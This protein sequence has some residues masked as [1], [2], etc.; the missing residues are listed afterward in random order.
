M[1]FRHPFFNNLRLDIGWSYAEHLKAVDSDNKPILEIRRLAGTDIKTPLNTVIRADAKCKVQ[2]VFVDPKNPYRNFI[3]LQYP[4]HF[5]EL[6][7]ILKP[8]VRVG[9]IIS[10][11][12]EIARTGASNRWLHVGRLNG[13]NLKT[14]KRVNPEP[15]LKAYSA[16]KTA[17]PLAPPAVIKPLPPKVPP[18]AEKP[19][20][21][22]PGAPKTTS[23]AVNS[24]FR[25]TFNRE[26]VIRIIE[27]IKAKFSSRKFWFPLL[28]V[29]GNLALVVA[30]D[31]SFQDAIDAI[32]KSPIVLLWLGLEAGVD[33]SRLFGLKK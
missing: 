18:P 14:A 33:I 32:S 29:L 11:G 25:F 4:D 6:G 31:K 28:V 20:V 30:G 26:V 12:V 10:A 9:Q 21:V 1:A 19:V 22:P 15:L 7:H 27:F 8:R 17:L 23:D 24:D 16:P 5:S 3:R 2:A 13:K